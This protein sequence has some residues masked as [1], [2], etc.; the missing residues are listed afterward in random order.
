MAKRGLLPTPTASMADR[1]GR[2]ELIHWVRSGGTTRRGT[3]PTPTETANQLSPSMG[4]WK[5]CR[6]LQSMAGGPGGQLHPRFVEWM[7]GFDD[8]WT[9]CEPSETPSYPNAPRSSGG[10]SGS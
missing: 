6:L 2:G 7:M 1:G 8:G 5:G 10:S 3:L 4:K 9:D